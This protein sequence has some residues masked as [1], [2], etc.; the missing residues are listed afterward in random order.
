MARHGNNKKGVLNERVAQ[1]S[2]SAVATR[3][4]PPKPASLFVMQGL[5]PPVVVLG[6]GFSFLP[7]CGFVLCVCED[8]SFD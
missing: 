8:L 1:T 6:C 4:Q 2:S 7:V 3:S 5:P